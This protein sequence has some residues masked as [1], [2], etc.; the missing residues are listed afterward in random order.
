MDDK[1]AARFWSKV[2]FLRGNGCWLWTASAN[3]KG[4][5]WFRLNGKARFAHRVAWGDINGPVPAGMQLDHRHTCPKNCIRPDHLRP[6]TNKQNHENLA[7]ANRNSKSGVRGVVWHKPTGLWFA[8]V[9]HN[10]KKYSC[11]YF[12]TIPEAENAVRLKRIELHSHNDADR[13]RKRL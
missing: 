8:N 13:A 10:G 2:D 4:Y 1:T 3:P 11:G 12:K 9:G 6:V 7:R 5:G